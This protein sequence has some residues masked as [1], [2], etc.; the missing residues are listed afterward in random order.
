MPEIPNWKTQWNCVYAFAGAPAPDQGFQGDLWIDKVTGLIYGPKIDGEWG[1]PFAI[2]GGGGGAALTLVGPTEPA[3][4]LTGALWINTAANCGGTVDLSAYY[5]KLEVDGLLAGLGGG[6]AT[7]DLT[8]YYTK[9]ETDAAIKV[10]ID[11][12]SATWSTD[13]QTI[14]DQFVGVIGLASD[15]LTAATD[16]KLL[17][18][19]DKADTYTKAE[20]DGLVASAVTGGTIDLSGYVENTQFL[21]TVQDITAQLAA[22]YTKDEVDAAV[23]AASDQAAVW[24]QQ[25]R[26]QTFSELQLV[27]ST[28]GTSINERPTLPQVEALIAAVPAGGEVVGVDGDSP[29]PS[30]ATPQGFLDAYAPFAPGAYYFRGDQ[31][32]VLVRRENSG[33]FTQLNILRQDAA[34]SVTAIKASDY[35]PVPGT[36]N[37]PKSR[38]VNQNGTSWFIMEAALPGDQFRPIG[39][40]VDIVNQQTAIQDLY[41]QI[42]GAVDME[43]YY[44]KPEVDALAKTITDQAAVWDQDV[45]NQ[46][47]GELQLVASSL[48][49]SLALKADKAA[50]DA[51]VAD[52]A[53]LASQQQTFLTQSDIDQTNQLL[54][55]LGTAT[56]DCITGLD[57][58]ADKTTVA[59]LGT[60]LMNS[61]M[62]VRNDAYTKAEADAKLVPYAKLSDLTGPNLAAKLSGQDI[63]LGT[64]TSTAS[65]LIFGDRS[66][67]A[68][69]NGRLLFVADEQNPVNM[70]QIAFLS[71]ISATTGGPVDLSAYAKLNDIGQEITA[72]L[73]KA[74]AFNFT[75]S[76]T[77]IGFNRFPEYPN[78]KMGIE[79]GGPGGEIQH[80]AYMSDIVGPHRF[81]PQNTLSYGIVS[82]LEGNRLYLDTGSK[83]YAVPFLGDVALKQDNG[84]AILAK[85]VVAQGIG[86]GDTNMPP[87]ALAY[88]DTG[89]GY[90]P[91]LVFAVGAVNDYVA[92]RSDFEPIAARVEALESRAAPESPGDLVATIKSVISGGA[93][94]PAD[95]PWT[96]CDLL[97]GNVAPEARCLNGIIYLRGEMNVT[98]TSTGSPLW[99][100]KLP[101]GFPLPVMSTKSVVYAAE[102]GVTY[103][104][105]MVFMHDDGA[106]GVCA[107]GKMTVVDFW[108]ASAPT[109]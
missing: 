108:G 45:V 50:L 44:T 51:A 12:A 103:R 79:I 48:G 54:Q 57:L 29:T 33:G 95:T 58:K 75:K 35:V 40:A 73:M 31:S 97:A 93:D 20:V 26:D 80:L 86:F 59:S 68:T 104:R 92:L 3:P 60:T 89:E 21:A 9:P 77:T 37:P 76:N 27:A 106:I 67:I 36:T 8:G 49:N 85:T 6:G 83:K 63:T 4:G 47:S 94:I 30:P 5:T 24:D 98:V 32:L 64:I 39:A 62:E 13:F 15:Q 19:A 69:A 28:L 99:V 43:V 16:A 14:S 72:N 2:G 46:Y 41:S 56:Q 88:T 55:G 53:A 11:A 66:A 84:Q 42:G 7:V 34:G 78:G 70:E 107:D 52:I 25:L 87:A 65:G 17:L 82:G 18:K 100:A 96:R 10:A 105:G 74:Q 90:G 81:D 61:I 109:F 71:D 23:Q 91:R 1:T 101:D 102:G 38:V 22:R